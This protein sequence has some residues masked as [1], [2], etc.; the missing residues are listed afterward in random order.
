[1]A[2]VKHTKNC[3]DSGSESRSSSSDLVQ[4]HL[5]LIGL[6]DGGLKIHVNATSAPRFKMWK[7]KAQ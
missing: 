1:M 7:G 4:D 5:T 6:A 2:L 3:F